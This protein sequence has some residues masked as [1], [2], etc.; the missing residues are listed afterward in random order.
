MINTNYKRRLVFILFGMILSASALAQDL[1]MEQLSA[2][3][4]R[5]YYDEAKSNYNDAT[6]R[7]NEQEKRVIQEQTLLKE[8]QDK[9]AAAKDRLANAKIELDKKLKALDQAWREKKQIKT[10]S[11]KQSDV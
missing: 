7:V 2:T 1:A 5:K 9:Q 11:T 3:A 8:R 6:T 4:A 10:H